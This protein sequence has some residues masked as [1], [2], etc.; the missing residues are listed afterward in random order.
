M[1]PELPTIAESGLPGLSNPET[2]YGVLVPVKTPRETIATLRNAVIATLNNQTLNSRLND[3]GYVTLTSQPEEFG[4]YIKLEIDRLG[5]VVR[6][7][8]LKPD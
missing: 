4:A 6:A 1:T 2:W 7:L 5:K 3:L 8:N